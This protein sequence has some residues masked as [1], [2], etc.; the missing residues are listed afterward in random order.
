MMS[1]KWLVFILLSPI[2]FLYNRYKGKANDNGIES[3]NNVQKDK[4]SFVW[5]LR[6]RIILLLAGYIRYM[7]IQVGLIPSH[8]IRDFI[9]K[10]V[11]GVRMEKNVI[12]YYGAEIRSHG[13]LR[14][15]KGS[16]IGDKAVLDARNGITIGENVN[17]SSEVQIWTEQHDHRDP[18]FACNSDETFRVEI[19]NR[20]W[21]GPR[22][23]LLHGITIGEG[24]VIAAGAVVTKDVPP[25]GIV[26]GIP[27][28]IIG[29][30]N[31]FL[32]YEFSDPPLPF[33]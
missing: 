27:A 16:I 26:A 7:D 30:R 3:G 11:F 10:R 20:A 9:Y 5:K 12:I 18:F 1:W 29:E 31:R 33:L 25:Y 24:A 23:I 15:G 4:S 32:K 13:K 6:Y 21:I 14:I 17:V 2:I 19:G 28:K 22:T 8:I